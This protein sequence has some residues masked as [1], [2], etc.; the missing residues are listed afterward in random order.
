LGTEDEEAFN[1]REDDLSAPSNGNSRNGC[2]DEMGAAIPC[3]DVV[4]DETRTIFDMNNP[5]MELRSLYATMDQFR[6]AIKQNAIIKEFELGIEATNKTRFR[7][8]CKG[9]NCPWSIRARSETKGS[10]TIQVMAFVI[11]VLNISFVICLGINK[12]SSL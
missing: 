12:N 5:V 6:L 4:L 2:E 1:Q 10:P 8:Y 9:P 7:G 11:F 3:S